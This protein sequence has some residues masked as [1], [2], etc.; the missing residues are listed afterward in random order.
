MSTQP[1]KD[2]KSWR[3]QHGLSQK[4]LA[5][6]AKVSLNTICNVEAGKGKPMK[7]TVKKLEEVFKA[8][9]S[10]PSAKTKL[11]VEAKPVVKRK[12]PMIDLKSFRK[13]HGLSQAKLAKLAKVSLNTICNVEA[14]KG[15]PMKGTVKKLEEAFKAVESMPGKAVP[16]AKLTRMVRVTKAKRKGHDK[17][18]KTIETGPIK[19]SNIDL[20]LFNR[21]LNM[22][23]GEKIEL[24]KKMM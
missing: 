5:E 15:T 8:V 11:T 13:K 14:G 20:E 16:K 12:E 1:I 17:P 21:V 3:K 6:L 23:E 9:E 7:G 4:K 18:R 24:L 22:S 19:L 2:L 10:K